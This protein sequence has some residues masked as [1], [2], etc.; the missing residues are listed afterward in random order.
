MDSLPQGISLSRKELQWYMKQWGMKANKKTEV[1]RAVYD[2]VRATSRTPDGRDAR[3]LP[4]RHPPGTSAA[5]GELKRPPSS[6]VTVASLK[7]TLPANMSSGAVAL[8]AHPLDLKPSAVAADASVAPTKTKRPKK[9]PKEKR[10]RPFRGTCSAATRQRIQRALSQTLYL[11]QRGE[12]NNATS[13][14]E[15]VVLGSTG[16]VYNVKISHLPSCSCPDSSKGHHCKHILF[17]LLKVM[18]LNRDSPHVYQ[19]A[20]LTSELEDMFTT[21]QNRRVGGVNVMAN[22]S[23]QKAYA[24]LQKGEEPSD[25]DA[26][27]GVKRKSLDDDAD[28]PIC[29]DAMNAQSSLTHCKAMCGTN[30]HADCIR[31]WC[32]QHRS[33]AT[34]PACR[35]PWQQDSASSSNAAGTN[36]EGYTN[37][38]SM[39]GVS[40]IRDTSTYSTWFNSPYAKRRRWY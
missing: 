33:N 10:L 13:E 29:F 22:A 37:L 2:S 24:S 16:N 6:S 36:T 5:G 30:F 38:G 25:G 11:V 40:P 27:G 23:V 26:A 12:I 7:P 9:I 14:C 17:V 1:M 35:Q 18:G 8:M 15:F 28:C 4:M 34:C 20:L 3:A 31:R 32:Q 21:M 39:Q 19:A